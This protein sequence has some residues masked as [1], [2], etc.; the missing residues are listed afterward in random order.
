MDLSDRRAG[1]RQLVRCAG[2][3]IPL[4]AAWSGHPPEPPAVRG[5]RHDPGHTGSHLQGAVPDRCHQGDHCSVACRL[6]CLVSVS[7]SVFVSVCQSLSLCFC[8]SFSL[9]F[10]LSVPQALFSVCQS[11]S[12]SLFLSVS[13]SVFVSV[14]Q[15]PQSLFLSQSLCLS[16][17]PSVCLPLYPSLSDSWMGVKY[18]FKKNLSA[19][20]ET[21]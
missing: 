11:L 12:Q 15:S 7:P 10:C 14:C 13:P 5:V 18:Y 19:M 16:L 20:L 1:G 4:L 3:Q 8:Q 21:A 2:L 9:C 17:S 6:V